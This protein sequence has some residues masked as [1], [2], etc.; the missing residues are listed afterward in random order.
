MKTLVT[1]GN[2]HGILFDNVPE[3]ALAALGAAQLVAIQGYGKDRVLTPS[4]EAIEITFVDDRQEDAV[5]ALLKKTQE[6]V[7][8]ANSRAWKAEEELKQFKKEYGA[9]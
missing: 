8:K 1:I 2:Y 4:T 9:L 3:G 7:S 6:E 5:V